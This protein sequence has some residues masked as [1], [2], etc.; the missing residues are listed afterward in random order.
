MLSKRATS[1][2]LQ[3]SRALI[4][5]M[6]AAWRWADLCISPKSTMAG[7][8]AFFFVA[9]DIY[10]Y[11]N[12]D[13]GSR[14]SGPASQMKNGDFSQTLGS[15]IGI[16]ALGRP[17]FQGEICDPSTTRTLANGTIARDPFMCNGQ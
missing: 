10:R 4:N 13:P 2:T 6:K 14:S 15:Q 12:S 17:I 7:I 11:R 3:A 8:E 9:L 1:S 16:D 5:R